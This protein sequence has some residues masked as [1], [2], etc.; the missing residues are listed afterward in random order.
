TARRRPGSRRSS[1]TRILHRPFRFRRQGAV[2]PEHQGKPS[3][4][5]LHRE[6]VARLRQR[7]RARSFRSRRRARLLSRPPP[8]GMG[9]IQAGARADARRPDR[10]DQLGVAVGR[11]ATRPEGALMTVAQIGLTRTVFGPHRTGGESLISVVGTASVITLLAVY[12]G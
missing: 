11:A 10:R 7:T 9:Q 4:Q 5:G 12:I 3:G 8:T 1:D 2:V 6:P